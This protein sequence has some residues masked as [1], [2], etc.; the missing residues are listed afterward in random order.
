[1]ISKGKSNLDVIDELL[2]MMSKGDKITLNDIDEI[3]S[4]RSIV[5][6]KA[7]S[8]SLT[9]FYSGEPENLINTIATCGSEIRIDVQKLLSS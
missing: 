5:D 3:I 4:T 9:I 2:E 6:T 7:S 8:D 1:M